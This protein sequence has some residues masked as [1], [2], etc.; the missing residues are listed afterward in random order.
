MPARPT[1]IVPTSGPNF[2]AYH[3]AACFVLAP[4]LA[5]LA[6]FVP[7]YGLSPSAIWQAQ[8][9]IFADNVTSAIAGHVYMSMWP[10][11]PLLVRPVWFL[12][13]NVGDDRVAAIVL[14]GN[15]LVLWPALAAIAI[16]VR[17]VIVTRRA[18]AFLIAAFYFGLYLAWAVLPR[19]LQFLYYYLPA[20]TLASLALVY[21]LRRGRQS[22]LAA[23]GVCRGR[24]GELCRDAAGL[25]GVRRHLDGDVQ[26][27]D[28]LPELDL[29]GADHRAAVTSTRSWSPC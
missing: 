23:V 26:P 28:D 2:R 20:A 13:D 15:P 10:S 6:S 12:F 24:G 9:R 18:D 14:L 17:D 11:W 27:A 1:G 22:A 25:G 3:V 4:A 21:A 19:T 8:R 29:S 7:L 5:Y 16:V